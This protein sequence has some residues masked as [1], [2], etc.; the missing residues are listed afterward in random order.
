MVT[1]V[2]TTCK[3]NSEIVHRAVRSVLTQTFSDWE[4]IVVDDS[5]DEF[6]GRNAVEECVLQYADTHKI[7]YLKNDQNS[8][9]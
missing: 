3:R 6:Q 7:W 9:A 8:G 2:I 4:L 5:P 1:V